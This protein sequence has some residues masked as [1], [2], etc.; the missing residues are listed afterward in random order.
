MERACAPLGGA[1]REALFAGAERRS[2][3]GVRNQEVPPLTTELRDRPAAGTRYYVHYLERLAGEPHYSR[4]TARDFASAQEANAY[5]TTL[6]AESK[7]LV[8]TSPEPPDMDQDQH[9]QS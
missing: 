2:G 5:A 3:L 6:A 8:T 9:D 4:A 7:P 1:A